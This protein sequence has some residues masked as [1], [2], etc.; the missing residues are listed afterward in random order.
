MLHL[1]IILSCCCVYM[2][3]IYRQKN[4]N[5]RH[6]LLFLRILANVL[7]LILLA[8]STY[9]IQLC[10]ER[11]RKLELVKLDNK[12]YDAGIWAE[13]EVS[14]DTSL[15]LLC[16][17]APALSLP[18]PLPAENEVSVTLFLQRYSPLS[19]DRSR[20]QQTLTIRD[21][22][23][24]VILSVLSLLFLFKQNDLMI[25]PRCFFFT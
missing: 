10:V 6:L 25:K 21:V 23:H 3:T 13:N 4:I 22:I 19:L 9:A 5:N 17:L 18:F 11:S 14:Y 8:L 16:Y 7:I 2:Q 12:D 20:D 24:S 1:L 15:G